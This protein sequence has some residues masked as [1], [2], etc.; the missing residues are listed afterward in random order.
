M[1]HG[2]ASSGRLNWEKTG[3][4]R[5]LT[6]AGHGVL[7]VDLRG[8]GN[9]AKSRR[10]EL[11]EPREMAED[12]F[13]VLTELDLPR[14][15]LVG[16]S[17]GAQLSRTLVALQPEL[18]SAVVL[19]G[20]GVS[21]PFSTWDISEVKAFLRDG[22]PM[23]NK[24]GT[25]LL[26]FALGAPDADPEA[27]IACIEGFDSDIVP[28]PPTVP[29]LLVA[30]DRDEIAEDAARFAGSIGADFVALPGRDHINALTSR[31]F[32]EAVLAFF[33]RVRG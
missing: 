19:G 30:G 14:A 4:V 8:H 26:R 31:H 33:D 16:Y 25:A 1:V 13:A 17:M 5:R 7:T 24:T 28:P 27:L 21:R 32:S 6:A 11:Y 3:W 12:V 22:V 23:G 2:F 15:S 9:S 10:P 20:I 29:A 18:F